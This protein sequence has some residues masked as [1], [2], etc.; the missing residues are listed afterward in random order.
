MLSLLV[1]CF[2]AG[3]FG[4]ILQGAVGIGTGI[5]V[6]PLLTYLLPYY[7]ISQDIA[8]HIALATS[9]AA[10]VVNSISA[11]ISHQKRGNV[12]WPLFKKIILFSVLG[13]CLGAV[14]ASFTSGRYLESIFGIFMLFTAFYMLLK[15]PANDTTD[16]IPEL[17]LPTLATGGFS[18]GFVASIIGTGGGILMVPFL[19]ALKVKMRYAVGTSTLIGLPVAIIGAA[20]YVLVGLSRIP[21]SSVT[22]GYLHW[23]AFLA[24]S[25]A[26]IL[27]A[28]YGAK[29]ATILPTKTLQRIFAVCM[30]FIGVKMVW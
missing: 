28:P 23:P 27:S 21:S 14:A 24:I 9:M 3:G 13:S 20:T 17:S 22:I 25:A 26:G 18:I 16:T 6:I 15:K 30:I 10:I 29:L 4:A 1:I 8:I 5:V 12:Q 2:I 11:L 19:H 7:G